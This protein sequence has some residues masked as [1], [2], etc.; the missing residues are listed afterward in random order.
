MLQNWR[1]LI[2]GNLEAIV[3]GGGEPIL[4]K[5][6]GERSASIL[7]PVSSISVLFYHQ[8]LIKNLIRK[9]IKGR[10]SNSFLGYIWTVLEPALL[11]T[12]YYFLFIMIAD[13][14]DPLY[15]V[16][17][18]IGVIIW[19][20]FGKVLQSTVTSLTRNASTIHLVYFPR[21]IFTYASVGSTIWITLMSSVVFIP[22]L[23][24]YDIGISW[25]LL[26]VPVAIL[27]AAFNAVGLGI[28]LAPTNCV[29]R[30]VEHLVRFIVRAGFF[31]SPV[32]WTWDMALKRGWA[33]DVVIWNPMVFPITLARDGFLGKVTEFPVDGI[34]IS[35]GWGIAMW[36]IGSMIFNKFEHS[37]VKYL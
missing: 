16:W 8:F 13:D 27:L 5:E 30:D 25:Q 29:N 4:L 18:I 6:V 28:L 34:L 9:D 37:A 15:P 26:F 20:C 17:V 7:S 22:L 11:S 31:L 14:P 21:I 10:Y 24:A 23:I 32:M 1:D 33:S 35:V 36:V 3:M 12:V 19:S 2:K